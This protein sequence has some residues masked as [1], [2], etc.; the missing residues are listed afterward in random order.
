MEEAYFFIK[1]EKGGM[2]MKYLRWIALLT[3]A[4]LLTACAA[5]EEPPAFDE[6]AFLEEI[7]PNVECLNQC[8]LEL[9]GAEV[10]VDTT[11]YGVYESEEAYDN[12]EG[13]VAK[14]YLPGEEEQVASYFEDP[15]MSSYYKVSNFQTNAE[16]RD[17]LRNYLSDAVIDEVFHDDFLEYEGALYL[18]RGSRGYGAV[19][20]DLDSLKFVE[21][22]NGISFVSRRIGGKNTESSGGK[23]RRIQRAAAPRGKVR[24]PHGFS[25]GQRSYYTLQGLSAHEA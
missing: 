21:Q 25:A 8:E 10:D 9:F 14:L 12:G 5:K 4:F 1:E 3:A 7:K 19:T 22:K 6:T 18:R 2:D 17:S 13:T 24:F 16:V 11:Y 15:T 23:K 20:I